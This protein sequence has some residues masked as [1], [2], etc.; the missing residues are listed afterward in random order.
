MFLVHVVIV[1]LL[2]L[3]ACS[4]LPP[5]P[6]Y[7]IR[8]TRGRFASARALGQL[9]A[10]T[11]STLVAIV[12][13]RWIIVNSSLTIVLLQLATALYL[14]HLACSGALLLDHQ[15]AIASNTSKP[16]LITALCALLLAPAGFLPLG[17]LS[18]FISDQHISFQQILAIGGSYIVTVSIYTSISGWLEAVT[19]C[20]KMQAYW[21]KTSCSILFIASAF[22]AWKSIIH[23]Y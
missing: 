11:L 18:L 2:S 13:A 8:K 21:A 16:R 17:I 19:P 6:L 7:F 15:P 22:I 20:R 10:V 12:L 9:V 23:I 5:G 1:I 14:A 3:A 4:A